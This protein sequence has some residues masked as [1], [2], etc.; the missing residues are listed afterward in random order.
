MHTHA[1]SH[2]LPVALLATV[3][4]SRSLPCPHVPS[5]RRPSQ[6][7]CHSHSTVSCTQAY[8][9]TVTH[10]YCHRVAHAHSR[11]VTH[12]WLYLDQLLGEPARIVPHP[13]PRSVLRAHTHM[14]SLRSS[15]CWKLAASP[16]VPGG[17][18]MLQAPCR[19][20]VLVLPAYL[21]CPLPPGQSIGS[22]CL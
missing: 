5:L 2:A 15:G 6:L 12:V 9:H 7:C 20:C 16:S 1:R 13:L 22:G 17:W 14:R 19:L 4:H 18:G 21:P 10:T 11:G 3:P 8:P